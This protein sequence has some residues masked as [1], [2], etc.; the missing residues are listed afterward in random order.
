ME[1]VQNSQE[2]NSDK[3]KVLDFWASWC[4]PCKALKP[5]IESLEQEFAGQIDLL[6]VEID[7]PINKG[8]VEK[9]QIQSIPT[10]VFEQHGQEI[11]RITGI[12]PKERYVEF[13]KANIPKEL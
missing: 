4:G 7:N 8:I 3:L 1:I 2:K 9:Y 12:N 6:K 11:G 13:I 5:T 10:V